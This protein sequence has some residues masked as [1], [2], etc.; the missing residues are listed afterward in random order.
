MTDLEKFLVFSYFK[1]TDKDSEEEIILKCAKRAYLDLCRTLRFNN[2]SEKEHVAFCEHVSKK[3][4]EEIQNIPLTLEIEDF[5][6]AHS[7]ICGR[8]IA[9]ATNY[10]SKNSSYKLLA[11]TEETK[12]SF[13]Y[14]QAQKWLNMTLKYMYLL[15]CR[16]NFFEKYSS[17][18]HVPVDR[19]IIKKAEGI[20]ENIPANAWSQWEKSTYIKFQSDLRTALKEKSPIDWEAD[21]WIDIAKNK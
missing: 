20:I 6:Y 17:F 8:I 7:E 12:K 14:G 2:N 18:L 11:E 13:N 9:F 3:I 16:S 19:Y 21:A 4:V 5:D 10:P 1:I 15:D